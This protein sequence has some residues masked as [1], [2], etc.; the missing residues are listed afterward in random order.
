MLERLKA[1]LSASGA[2]YA[3]V[4]QFIIPEFK[5]GSKSLNTKNVTELVLF[6]DFN[7]LILIR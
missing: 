1:K 4:Y 2:D 3:E 7:L 5:A 6:N